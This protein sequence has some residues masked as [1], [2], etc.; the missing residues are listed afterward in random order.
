MVWSK[1]PRPQGRASSG[2]R[3]RVF[4]DEQPSLDSVYPARANDC[5]YPTLF[6]EAVLTNANPTYEIT[7]SNV[8]RVFVEACPLGLNAVP[9]RSF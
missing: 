6:A 8:M 4:A 5:R 7:P 1:V 2:L 3:L 9:F